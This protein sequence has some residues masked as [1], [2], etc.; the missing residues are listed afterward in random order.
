MTV[1][2][3]GLG[4]SFKN[5]ILLC[6]YTEKD[7]EVGIVEDQLEKG[8]RNLFQEAKSRK[9]NSLVIP[10]VHTG[11]YN[12]DTVLIFKKIMKI[13]DAVVLKNE[14]HPLKEIIICE[15]NPRKVSKIQEYIQ[16]FGQIPENQ[17]YW[18]SDTGFLPYEK[19]S[20]R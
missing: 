19:E 6:I 4:N 15:K 20:N 10:L 5:I 16:T 13:I 2:S 8:L 1:D 14:N 11:V 18:K 3:H 12:F 17:W 7:E 9:I